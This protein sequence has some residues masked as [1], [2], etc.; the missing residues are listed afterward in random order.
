MHQFFLVSVP[1]RGNGLWKL[2]YTC[3]SIDSYICVSV[4]LRGNGLWKPQLSRLSHQV[5]EVSVPLRGNGL[6][7]Q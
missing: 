6:W 2:S 1:L 4:P 5:G 3:K 7:K